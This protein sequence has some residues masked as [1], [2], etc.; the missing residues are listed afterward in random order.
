MDD[1][2]FKCESFELPF[3]KYTLA[4]DSFSLPPG[5]L[6]QLYGLNGSHTNELIL[7]LAG[8]HNLRGATSPA[9]KGELVRK[10]L[11]ISPE[12]LSFLRLRGEP[13]YGYSPLERARAVGIIFE[14]PELFTVGRTVL[15]DFQYSFA[16]IGRRIPEPQI[17]RRY[18]LFEK[19]SRP[20]QVLS[21]GEQHRLNCASIFELRHALVIADFSAS[22]LDVDFM[23][24]AT[25]WLI[26]LKRN[27]S[28]VLVHGLS[29]LRDNPEVDFSFTVEEGRLS[30]KRPEKELFP[31]PPEERRQL[32]LLLEAREVGHSSV[33]E[34]R[35]VSRNDRI[36]RPVSFEVKDR[37]IVQVWGPNGC[38]K[39]SL[40]RIIVKA[41][42]EY[43]GSFQF[44]DGVQPRLCPQFPE[45][46]FLERTVLGEVQDEHLLE[47]IGLK[48]AEWGKHPRAL[49][50][51][52]QKLLG[53]L[54][55]LRHSVGL[56]ILD[57][58]T[59]G[60]DFV[61]KKLFMALLN[62]FSDRAVV[63]ITHDPSLRGIGR[64]IDWEDIS[65]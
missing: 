48:P 57:E 36:T 56:A 31:T 22:N 52:Q 4:A 53:A 7:L 16:A 8:L 11:F 44:A 13:L 42:R 19:Q 51:S 14:N 24:K 65:E 9:A 28:T 60:L 6:A 55:A 49:N 12:Q 26:E 20:T 10:D 61:Y 5:S 64:I 47:Q 18:D 3:S 40:A 38:G 62:R 29:E 2:T 33:L 30:S 21:G 1:L 41:N 54:I 27:G 63:M 45:R 46:L 25:D 37:E 39:T 35:S 23:V 43:I 32:E 59:S 50:H 17:L 34:V 58:P 15:E